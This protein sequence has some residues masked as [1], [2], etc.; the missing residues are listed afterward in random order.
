[1][2]DSTSWLKRYYP[3]HA[4]S[5]GKKSWAECIEHCITKWRGFRGKVL[6]A[7]GLHPANC[8]I[9]ADSSRVVSV[10][11]SDCALCVKSGIVESQKAK[12][13][14]HAD[15]HCIYCPLYQVRDHVKC[16]VLMAPET[17]SPWGIFQWE[18][19]PEPMVK[20]LVK[21]RNYQR[22]MDSQKRKGK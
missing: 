20:W 7:Y 5:M 13:N 18:H 12:P 9:Y 21:A 1:M 16:H 17:R 3:V 19:N 11:D 10:Y 15:G 4:S 6:D 2:K 14:N 22:R 8:T